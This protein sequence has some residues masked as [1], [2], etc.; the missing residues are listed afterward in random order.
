M[1]AHRRVLLCDRSIGRDVA[2][3]EVV[4]K[5]AQQIREGRGQLTQ[6]C[7]DGLPKK[8]VRSRRPGVRQR[9]DAKER[10]QDNDNH[11]DCACRP[12]TSGLVR[13]KHV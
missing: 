1:T 10:K 8:D 12:Q 6:I 13:G 11:T 9:G 2:I 4:R 3:Q 5:C 7:E